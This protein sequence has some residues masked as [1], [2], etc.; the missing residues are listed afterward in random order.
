MAITVMDTVINK[1]V[2]T[3]IIIAII[4]AK[5]V[6]GDWQFQPKLLV[7]ET[8]SNN[9][10]L[11][12][13]GKQSSL[14]SQTG[15]GFNNMFTSNKLDFNFTS[16]SSFAMYSHNHELDKDYHSLASDIRL[17]LWPDGLALIGS[18]SISNEARNSSSNALA[19]I[20]SA[21]TIRVERYT[22][23][24][25]YTVNNRSFLMSS[26]VSYQL[27][28]SQ[29]NVGE[30]DGYSANFISK[31][32]T[33]SRYI[34]WD[35]TASYIDLKNNNIEGSQFKGEIKVGLIT[36]YKILPFLRY[37]DEY[38]DGNISNSNT[39]LDSNSYG[40]GLRLL[41]S[42]K[43]YLDFSYNKPIN[44]QLDLDGNEQKNHTSA[45]IKWEPTQRTQL[46]INYGQRFYGE[47][48]EFD[49]THKNRRLTNK[50]SYTEDVEL[51][52]R[53]NYVGI[54]QGS[55]WCPPDEFTVAT[56]C[57]I[58]SDEN[59][60]FDDYQLV[61][62]SDFVLVEDQDLSLNKSFQW[63]STLALPRTTFNLALSEVRRENLTTQVE[64]ENVGASFTIS[65]KISGNSALNLNLQYTE[66]HYSLNQENERQDRYRRYS[67]EYD[68]S[69]NSE[70]I[71]KFGLSHL[72][73]SSTNQSLNYEEDRIYL[74][75]SKGF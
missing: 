45:S 73:R 29:D 17:K 23:G 38:N 72:N 39:S 31:N 68:K 35:A 54:T 32:G 33:S 51:F 43:L 41:I 49:F 59:I 20:V 66:T 69:L 36:G 9:V 44:N 75:F 11:A 8:Y 21:D 15:I 47:S 71:V 64:D 62:L 34:Y 19:D 74:N 63:N 28:Q 10:T 27:S 24:L 52:T 4:S 13:N 5:S 56:S 67:L 61:T 7:D 40:A 37:Y 50:I 57:Y 2:L 70:F 53:N 18:A 48:Y 65:R 30:R 3:A 55:Y 16:K 12:L 25:E 22:G 1:K 60:N 6:A 26:N 46:N 14:V 42:S 58:K